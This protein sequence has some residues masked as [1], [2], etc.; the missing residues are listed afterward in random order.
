MSSTPSLRRSASDFSYYNLDPFLLIIPPFNRR[1]IL[2]ASKNT[3]N[4]IDR[5]HEGLLRQT[6]RPPSQ[7]RVLPY[8]I[9]QP[10]MRRYSSSYLPSNTYR[11]VFKDRIMGSGGRRGGGNDAGSSS[12]TRTSRRRFNSSSSAAISGGNSHTQKKPA[13]AVYNIKTLFGEKAHIGGLEEAV[14]CFCLWLLSVPLTLMCLAY[15]ATFYCLHYH[16]YVWPC[17]HIGTTLIAALSPARQHVSKRICNGWFVKALVRYF[18][19]EV[20]SVYVCM[21]VCMY[22]STLSSLLL[23]LAFASSIPSYLTTSRLSLSTRMYV[24]MY[25]CT[26]VRTYVCMYA[27][28][29]VCMYVR[30]YVRTIQVVEVPLDPTR[31]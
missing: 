19:G 9:S 4:A 30:M 24:C 31:K 5:L 26:Y 27:C 6:A 14:L 29:Y 1:I 25:V 23:V 13:A 22:V 10:Q 20:V 16:S 21:Y 17:I 18:D 3:V 7:G 12:T 11:A 15:A 28:M 8:Q 2:E